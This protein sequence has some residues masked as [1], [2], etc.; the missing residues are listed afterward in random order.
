MKLAC[1]GFVS[2]SAGSGTS[3]NT[4][5]LKQLLARGFEVDFF[6][7]PSFIDPRP[8]V[9][10]MAG[11]R[12]VPVENRILDFV[13]T[14]LEAVPLLS[15]AAGIADAYSYSR[16]VARTIAR[17]HRHRQYDLCVW[18]GDYARGAIRSLPSLSFVQG[19]PGTD[20]RSILTHSDQI[21]HLAGPL[22]SFK[23]Q[24]LARLRLSPLG[25]PPIRY[26]DHF[27]VGSKQ[28]EEALAKLYGVDPS[29]ISVLPH[30]V[31]LQVFRP[32]PS[33][34]N[35]SSLRVL[36][37]G[38]IVP[39]KRLDIFLDGAA[40][41]IRRGVD[42]K[43][44]MV[45]AATLIPEYENMIRSFPYPDRLERLA[46]VDRTRVP[47]FLS[48]HDVLAQPS[49]EENFGSSVA[50]AQACGIPVIVGRTNGNADYL[51]A[52]DI[53]LADERSE[54]FAEAL[55]EMHQ[56]KISGTLG[57][58]ATS[59]SLAEAYFDIDRV[60]EQLIQVLEKVR[61]A[62]RSGAS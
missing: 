52:R 24:I 16:L 23:W 56:R 22:R 17:E 51:C 43:L 9:G 20:A 10:Y 50:E 14:K 11:F 39:R 33:S 13:R 40:Q 26:S 5:V 7:K 62:G 59:R 49:D 4:L 31:D 8:I 34:T 32:T 37:L 30:P 3:A 61:N 47:A 12:F 1:T 44:T 6:S 46:P 25:L 18:L 60:M 19:P 45:G 53:H 35:S 41:A 58:P 2:A 29:H 15:T 28:S 21:R 54:T 55:I 36:W 38:R 57:D 27:F 48:G 42:L